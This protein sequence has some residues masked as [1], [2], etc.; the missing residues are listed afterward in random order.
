[1]DDEPVLLAEGGYRR[2]AEY[3]TKERTDGI[4]I[5]IGRRPWSCSRSLSGQLP[6]P[7]RWRDES[8]AIDIPDRVLWSRRGQK[9]NSFGAYNYAS[10][11]VTKGD[12]SGFPSRAHAHARDLS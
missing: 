1:M 4:V 12:L 9:E 11:I 7:E 3:L 5:P 10:Y 6:P 2:L 8:G